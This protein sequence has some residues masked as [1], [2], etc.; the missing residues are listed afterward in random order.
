MAAAQ[1]F[2]DV[3]NLFALA[4]WTILVVAIAKKQSLLRDT[5]AGTIWPV[6][7]SALYVIATGLGW[8][9]TDGGFLS[10]QA[11]RDH[12]SGDWPMLAAWVHY[13]AFDLFIGA[14]IAAETERAGLSRLV[15]VPVLPLTYLFGPVGFLLFFVLR[16]AQHPRHR[17]APHGHAGDLLTSCSSSTAPRANSPVRCAA[18]TPVSP[19]ISRPS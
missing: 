10:L 6:L 7:L 16:H 19:V 3:A 5:V 4:G 15:L 17:G 1:L 12:L 13:L 2:F 9:T 8:S 18:V 11:V 14:W